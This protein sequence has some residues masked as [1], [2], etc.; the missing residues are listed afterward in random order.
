MAT[1]SS[2]DMLIDLATDDRDA[3]ATVLGQLRTAHQ[4]SEQQLEALTTYRREYQRRFND[5]MALGMSMAALHNYQR[6]VAALDRAIAQQ[7]QVLSSSENQVDDGKSHWQSR[8]RRLKSFDVLAVR[9]REAAGK[10]EARR[11]QHQND[12][13]ASRATSALSGF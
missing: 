8:Q 12:E 10:A 7:R 5:A 6:F 13:Y 3:A 9:R 11:E 2:L 1:S 4:Q